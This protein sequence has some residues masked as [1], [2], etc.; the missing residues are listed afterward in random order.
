M[1]TDTMTPTPAQQKPK[2]HVAGGI[3][4][5]IGVIL[6]TIATI[7]QFAGGAG[8]HWGPQLVSNA[9]VYLI[10]WAMVGA[11]VSHLLFGKK[12]SKTIGFAQSPYEIEVGWAD[13]AM[14]I[15][16]LMSVYYSSDFALAI[17]FVSSIYRVG[18]GLGHVRSM[19]RDRNFAPNNTL[20]LVINFL[21]PAFLI[22]AFYAWN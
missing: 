20:I 17:I 19:I 18:C 12:I 7:Q 2:R 13:L 14:G 5:F 9:V 16:A 11:G 15:V 6:F 22:Y 10:G 4:P 21:V 8:A 3:L 1:S